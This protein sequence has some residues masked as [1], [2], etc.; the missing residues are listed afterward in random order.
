MRWMTG[1]TIAAINGAL[2]RATI[3]TGGPC[4]TAWVRRQKMLS[5]GYMLIM[6]IIGIVLLALGF[7]IQERS[8]IVGGVLM[9]AVGIAARFIPRGNGR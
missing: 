2:Q 4:S 6:L 8:L 9:I 1:A 5:R 7:A 3:N